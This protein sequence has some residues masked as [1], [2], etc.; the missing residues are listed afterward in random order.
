MVA[1]DQGIQD[2]CKEYGIEVE[3]LDGNSDSSTQ[4]TQ[5]EDSITKGVDAILLAPNNS[6]E[7]VAR[8]KKS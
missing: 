2:K 1:L 8:R 6:E 4:I 3:V 5:I 7:L